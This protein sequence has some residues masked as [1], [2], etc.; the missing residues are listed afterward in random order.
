MKLSGPLG[1]IDLY[2]LAEFQGHLSRGH[3]LIGVERSNFDLEYLR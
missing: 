3:G 1:V 2:D